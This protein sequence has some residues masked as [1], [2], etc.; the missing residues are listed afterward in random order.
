MLLGKDIQASPA[1]TVD[2]QSAIG[3]F[4]NHSFNSNF[5]VLALFHTY[6]SKYAD[7]K[8]GK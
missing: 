2:E 7:T 8:M 6:S 1:V 3:S 4:T 5:V